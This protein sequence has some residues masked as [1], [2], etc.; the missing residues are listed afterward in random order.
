MSIEDWC[1][2][3]EKTSKR[4]TPGGRKRQCRLRP[5]EKD[6]TLQISYV[7]TQQ[8]GLYQFQI[9]HINQFT[10]LSQIFCS[11]TSNEPETR[12]QR[13]NRSLVISCK[14]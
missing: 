7:Y 3:P 1:P 12:C 9:P 11:F 13:V 8:F 5:C 14:V 6:Y 10:L 2:L 4:S